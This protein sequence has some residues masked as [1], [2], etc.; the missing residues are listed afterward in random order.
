MKLIF[1]K[2]KLAGA[3]NLTSWYNKY[4][5]LKFAQNVNLIDSS[6]VKDIIDG[7]GTQRFTIGFKKRDGSFRVMNAQKGVQRPY[8]GE[9]NYINYGPTEYLT[10]YDLQIASQIARQS[11][12]DVDVGELDDRLL[13]KAYRRVYPHTVEL[14]KGGG[15]IYVV[16]G[17]DYAIENGFGEEVAENEH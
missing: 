13:R 15:E 2:V 11:I 8:K 5:Q 1:A 3:N 17:S 12:G 10:L 4:K 7:F 14:I 9:D 16:R 6:E